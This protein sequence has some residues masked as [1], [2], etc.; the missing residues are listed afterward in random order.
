[1]N[2][3]SSLWGCM[4]GGLCTLKTN[5]HLL[6]KDIAMK[7]QEILQDL[8]NQ[9]VCAK[10]FT[11]PS[12]AFNYLKEPKQGGVF[13]THVDKSY[14]DMLKSLFG[15]NYKDLDST[16]VAISNNVDSCFYELKK[17]IKTTTSEVG[18][19]TGNQLLKAIEDH[20][21]N[22]FQFASVAGV[23]SNTFMSPHLRV[24]GLYKLLKAF[25]ECNP[26]AI[27]VPLPTVKFA[28]SLADQH[29]DVISWTIA[30]Y[31]EIYKNAFSLF[32]NTHEA[33]WNEL[34]ESQTN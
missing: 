14:E 17:L 8:N 24:V 31:S 29:L 10:F 26:T 3:M 34:Y 16:S 21:S 12:F 9:I 23:A 28:K 13:L 18:H 1:M 19:Y 2:T 32:G 6:F 20:S 30:C 15:D 27:S 25:L 4:T 22:P 33:A 5:P 7:F 11:D